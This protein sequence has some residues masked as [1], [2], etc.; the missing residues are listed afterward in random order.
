[1]QM[2]SP[3]YCKQPVNEDINY[4]IPSL[5]TINDTEEISEDDDEIQQSEN[6]SE[7]EMY[8]YEEE[9]EEQEQ[10]PIEEEKIYEENIKN[11]SNLNESEMVNEAVAICEEIDE[12][13][14]D[15][16]SDCESSSSTESLVPV[17]QSANPEY[18][19]KLS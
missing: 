14:D 16:L 8:E 7:E 17:K 15:A 1:M 10:Q 2:K 6:N 5:S 12:L 13:L 19:R 3:I 11:N 4:P 9:A 18:G